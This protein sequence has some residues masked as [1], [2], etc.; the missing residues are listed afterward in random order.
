[1]SPASANNSGAG[2]GDGFIIRRGAR[3]QQPA[4]ASAEAVVATLAI[5]KEPARHQ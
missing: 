5:T 1:M 2:R 3:Q 4:P